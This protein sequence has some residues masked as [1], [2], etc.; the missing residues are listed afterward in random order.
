MTI[1]FQRVFLLTV[2][3]SINCNSLCASELFHPDESV[4]FCAPVTA[5]LLK[6]MKKSDSEHI[7]VKTLKLG[8]MTIP[9]G[10]K[11]TFDYVDGSKRINLKEKFLTSVSCENGTKASFAS[12]TMDNIDLD[13]NQCLFFKVPV[14]EPSQICGRSF[15][16]NATVYVDYGK[17][18]CRRTILLNVVGSRADLYPDR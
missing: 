1:P 13:Q 16:R 15:H 8:P 5:D 2:A 10:C 3:I 12:L 7:F 17:L 14:D 11:G 6:I 18:D 9:R 4:H